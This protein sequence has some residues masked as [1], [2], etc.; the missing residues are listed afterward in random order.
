MSLT[1]IIA[2]LHLSPSEPEIVQKFYFFMEH[3]APQ[4]TTLILLGDIFE[5]WIGDDDT[6][7]FNHGVIEALYE[8]HQQG[9]K[10]YFMHGNRDFGIGETFAK[11]SG[12]ELLPDPYLYR[13]AG[14][15]TLLLHGDS[16][17]TDDVVYQRYREKIRHPDMIARLTKL[18][19]WVRRL[20]ASYL[21]YRSRLYHRFNGKKSI[22]D[23]NTDTVI[24]TCKQYQVTR[25][26]HGHTHR[27][28]VHL[29]YRD[30]QLFERWVLSDWHR[31]GNYMSIDEQGMLQLLYF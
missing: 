6:S 22:M 23:V 26:I 27:P 30:G 2:D 21:R 13:Q 12:C 25:M 31:V 19:L 9:I 28:A 11:L 5:R 29:Y 18:P 8:L 10:L 4:A 15:T 20:I 16:L 1:Y 3:I 24:Q 17:C 7:K 14:V